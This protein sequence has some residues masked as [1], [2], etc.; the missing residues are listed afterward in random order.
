M[1][2]LIT[3]VTS[4]FG[5]AI[6]KRLAKDNHTIIGTG[7]RANKLANIKAEIGENFIPLCFDIGNLDDTKSALNGLD[8]ELLDNID[9]LINNAGLALGLETADKANIGDWQTMINTNILGLVNMTN[10]ILPYMVAKNN[11]LIINIGS[12]AGNYPYFGANVYGA[13]KAF[14]K[15]FSLNLR[16][17]LIGKNV[18]VTNIE[19]GLCGGTEFSNVRFKGDDEKASKLYEKVDYIR[20]ED[21]ADMVNYVIN[22]P[23][24]I[25]INRLEVMP[26]AQ[27][28]AG[29]TVA[30]D[31]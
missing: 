2:I 5:L 22:L 18:R 12:T 1:N 7:R 24:H 28:F 29:L 11:G 17:D 16:A 26:V 19:P 15:Q 6:A 9:V 30:K 8:K 21:I 31:M 4:G 13:S 27:T 23:P 3:G 10:S 14:V 25:N 20:P